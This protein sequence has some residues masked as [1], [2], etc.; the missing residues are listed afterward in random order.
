MERRKVRRERERVQFGGG[1]EEE[2]K[3]RQVQWRQRA[4]ASG[5]VRRLS[6]F[7][8]IVEIVRL[9]EIKLPSSVRVVG[10]D[11]RHPLPVELQLRLVGVSEPVE[12]LPSRE[13]VSG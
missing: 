2:A 12:R 8:Q 10:E 13:H 11:V 6:G 5:G 1:E 3:G 4:G 7:A 9:L